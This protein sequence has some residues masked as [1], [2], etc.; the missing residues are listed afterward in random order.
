MDEWYYA[1]IFDPISGK[2][3]LWHDIYAS[4]TEMAQEKFGHSSDG[5]GWVS[6]WGGTIQKLKGKSYWE[7]FVKYMPWDVVEQ[8]IYDGSKVE[9]HL[10]PELKAKLDAKVAELNGAPF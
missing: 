3:V 10:P 5:N 9:D 4:H 1:W 2:F 8:G 6:F 7:Y